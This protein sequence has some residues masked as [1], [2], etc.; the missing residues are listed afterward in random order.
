MRRTTSPI[1]RWVRG[2]ATV[3]IKAKGAGCAQLVVETPE[4]LP[5]SP[6]IFILAMPKEVVLENGANSDICPPGGP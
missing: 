2:S 4:K 5:R 6:K 1:F 3:G